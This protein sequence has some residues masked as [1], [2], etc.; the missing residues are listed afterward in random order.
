MRL[1]PRDVAARLGNETVDILSMG[2]YRTADGRDVEIATALSAAVAGTVAYQPER[3]VEPSPAPGRPR[4]FVENATVLEAGRRMSAAGAVAALNFASATTPGGGFL[5]GARAQEESIARSSG[6]Y[7]CLRDQEMYA[8]HRAA[9]DAMYADDVLYSPAVPVFRL[10]DG[11]LLDEPW[12]L[13]VITSPA[14]HGHGIERYAPH[15]RGEIPAAM[16]SRVRKVL[17]VAERHGDRRLILGAWG[18]GAFGLDAVM[19]AEIFAESLDAH[20]AVFDEV[21]FVSD[22]FSWT[23][24]ERGIGWPRWR[25]TRDGG[26]G[27]ASPKTTRPGRPGWSWMRARR[28][29]R[30]RA[31]WG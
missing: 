5:N 17:G 1:L 15:R 4:V 29:R 10:D 28:S 8:R 21:V 9:R 31:I 18:C 11:T 3:P 26:R 27:G 23:P 22:P 20:G 30:Q 6:L 7:A 2:R 12:R 13:N 16:R 25:S 24:S 19:M 14:V